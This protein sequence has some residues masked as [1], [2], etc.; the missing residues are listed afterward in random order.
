MDRPAKTLFTWQVLQATLACAPV[1]GNFVCVVWSKT[2][3]DQFTVV[4]QMEQSCGKPAATWF[5][6]VPPGNPSVA[7]SAGHRQAR[8][9]VVHVARIAGYV[10]VRPGQRNFV[11]VVWLT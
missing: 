5:G 4:W 1:K 11:W 6:L 10:D 3:P 2:A 9:L 7:G 8:E